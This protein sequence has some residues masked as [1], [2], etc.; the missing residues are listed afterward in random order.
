MMDWEIRIGEKKWIGLH[1]FD[2]R[3]QVWGIVYVPFL[4]V[5]TS[6]GKYKKLRKSVPL[7]WEYPFHRPITQWQPL[8]III[9]LEMPRQRTRSSCLPNEVVPSYFS[10]SM[11]LLGDVKLISFCCEEI[12]KIFLNAL[13]LVCRNMVVKIFKKTPIFS[14]DILNKIVWLVCALM[15]VGMYGG[16]SRDLL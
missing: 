13:I 3:A 8:I 5:N 9:N 12:W 6:F 11:Q 14:N 10:L 15:W 4:F 2:T 16:L 1:L 7:V